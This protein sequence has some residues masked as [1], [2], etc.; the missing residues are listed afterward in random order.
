MGTAD[1]VAFA[2]HPAG[3][4]CNWPCARGFRAERHPQGGA[5]TPRTVSD[6]D[7]LTAGMVGR[8][9]WA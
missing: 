7:L 2:L 3:Q 9:S 5:R 1:S 6:T 4:T 8:R